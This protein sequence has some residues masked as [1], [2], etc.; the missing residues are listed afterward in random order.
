VVAWGWN[1]FGQTDV[2]EGLAGVIA[3]AAGY[4]HSLALKGDGKVVAW[5]SNDSGQATV[6]DDLAGVTAIAAGYYHSMAK[7]TT[8][9]V[10]IGKARV[11]EGDRGSKKVTLPVR[12]SHSSTR[13]VRV[14]WRTVKGTAKPGQDY[15]AAKGTLRIAAG[16]TKG[17]V[18]V[19]VKGDRIK[20]RTERCS[21][22][23]PS[24]REPPS[25]WPRAS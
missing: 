3:V 2:P 8:I 21:S 19:R 12:L 11:R 15:V 1:D 10:S 7:V 16:R 5:G 22:A 24:P 9:R 23:C 17:K 13:A 6:P 20:E 25:G 14:A 4:G 18:V